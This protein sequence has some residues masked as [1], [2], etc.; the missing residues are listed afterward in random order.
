VLRPKQKK[1]VVPTIQ[2]ERAKC[3]V[4]GG[5]PTQVVEDREEE[6]GLLLLSRERFEESEQVV[7]LGQAGR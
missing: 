5:D 3:V 1:D 6:W 2:D 4:I 7:V